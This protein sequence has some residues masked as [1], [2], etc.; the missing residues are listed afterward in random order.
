MRSTTRIAMTLIL[1]GWLAACASV[2]PSGEA[3]RNQ[4]LQHSAAALRDMNRV[5]PGVDDLAR[6]G[7]GYAL[8]PEVVKGGAGLG[9]A[10]GRGV[11][12]E[13]G[14]HVGYADLSFA[15]I[16][17]QLGGQT[18]SEL[19]VF[20]NK[21]ALARFQQGTLEFTADASAIILNTGA[22]AN[23]RFV[24]GVL[25]IVRPLAGAMAEAA[26]GGQQFRYVPK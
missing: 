11:V 3:A 22:A 20:E 26:I 23:A 19:I 15:S 18:Y 16:G 7:H 5:D 21:E 9:G 17:A 6:K 4:I 13:Q 24:D 25:V 12:Y 8:F 14:Q 10:Y 1:A 2:A